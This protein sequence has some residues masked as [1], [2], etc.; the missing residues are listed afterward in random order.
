M[1]YQTKHKI[2]SYLQF[3]KVYSQFVINKLIQKQKIQ[4]QAMLI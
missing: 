3:V 1:H 2:Y 4:S